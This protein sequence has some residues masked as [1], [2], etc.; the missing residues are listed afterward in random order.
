[1]IAVNAAIVGDRPT[2]LG[3]YALSLIR[4]LDALGERLVVYTS[5]PEVVE[6]PGARI[7][8]VPYE[9]GRQ[10]L[11]LRLT[12]EELSL[13][14]A[15]LR[16]AG[17]L[18]VNVQ[19]DKPVACTAGQCPKGKPA[20]PGAPGAGG[21]PVAPPNGAAPPGAVSC[22]PGQPC[23]AKPAAPGETAQVSSVPAAAS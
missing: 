23:G 22:A 10:L 13:R 19:A 15:E 14:Q 2:G 21:Q 8:R 18:R 7:E 11:D 16:S 9:G 5:R 17:W 3:R 1:M 12:F 6:A 20:A 4:E